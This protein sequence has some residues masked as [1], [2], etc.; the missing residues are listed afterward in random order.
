MNPKN[1]QASRPNIILIN[2]DDL[3]FGDLGC[4]GSGVNSTP[5]LDR[6]AGEGL[7]LTHFSMAASVCSPSRGAM[8]TGCYPPRIGF[9]SFD[10]RPVLFPGQPVGLSPDETSIATLLKRAG[11]AT[12]LVG[13]WHC[14][15]QPEFLPTRHGFDHYYGL[16]YSNDMGRQAGREVDFPPLPLLRDEEVIEAQPDQAS[17]IERY[18][19]EAVRF[20]RA[21]RDGPFFLYLA[22]MQVHLPLFAPERFMKQ[23]RNGRYGAAVECVDWSTEVLLWELE[24]LGLT[25]NTLVIFTSDNGSNGRNGG[26]NGGLRGSKG[27]AWEGGF[28]VP[29]V[30]RWPGV[31]APGEECDAPV[32]AM[33]FLPTF[34]SLAGVD[35]RCG[36][37]IDGCDAG[38]VLFERTG[39]ELER[40]EMF[41]Y[42]GEELC[43]VRR[44]NWKY[45]VWNGNG[46]ELFELGTDPGESCNVLLDHPEVA[47]ELEELLT[48]CRCDLG[49]SSMGMRG[50]GVRPIGRVNEAK[51]LTEFHPDCPYFEAE[52]DLSDAE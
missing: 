30:M 23:S 41:Y 34:A 24:R 20:I 13:K 44:G 33:D 22:H 12:S 42:L 49:D 35:W 48:A 10:D 51:P 18:T 19:E 28:R 47:R 4:Y 52:Y 36:R 1:H 39:T 14:G 37:R 50:D 38:G 16:P 26:S 7:R 31:I 2:C 11:Y 43:A 15:D 3:G 5:C 32:S 9:G 46:P 45:H 27:S 40:T 8:L 6:M 21:E 25:E 17:L 29:C